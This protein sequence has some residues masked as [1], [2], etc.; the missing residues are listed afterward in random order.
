[1][2][3]LAR[4]LQAQ[5]RVLRAAQAD[6]L[7]IDKAMRRRLVKTGEWHHVVRGGY[8][9]PPF[10]EPELVVHCRAAVVRCEADVAISRLTR[11]ALVTPQQQFEGAIDV[12]VLRPGKVA[13][14]PGLVPHEVGTL[15]VVEDAHWPGLPLLSLPEAVVRSWVHLR[16]AWDRE[17]ALCSA[18]A[19]RDGTTGA[20]VI[21]QLGNRRVRGR[22]AL[23]AA[24]LDVD[25]GCESPPEL[26]YLRGVEREFHLPTPRRQVPIEV[27]P[28]LVFR[29]DCLYDDIKLI[30]EIDGMQ[31]KSKKVAEADDIRDR[32]LEALG[33]EV[34]RVTWEQLRDSPGGVAARVREA[35][36]RR[37]LELLSA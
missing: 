24:C 10:S 34:L 3:R 36:V 35:V 21:R 30:V 32:L 33:Y 22:V 13:A 16:S 1:M 18:T 6:A 8:A 4:L 12:A 14:T 19:P 26:R 28:G 31:H 17:S 15:V 5:H 23:I 25:T 27:A 2:D 11:I 29:V 7:G 9:V 20:D 37:R